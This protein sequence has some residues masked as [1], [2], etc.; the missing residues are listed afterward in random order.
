MCVIGDV[1]MGS[2]RENDLPRLELFV[3][4]YRCNLRL[5]DSKAESGWNNSSENAPIA[6]NE[7]S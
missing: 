3:L 5:S 1:E 6:S 7:C 2:D 4:K